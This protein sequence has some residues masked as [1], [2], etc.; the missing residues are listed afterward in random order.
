MIGAF[1]R[2]IRYPNLLMIIFIQYIVRY[3]LVKPV[4]AI[5]GIPLQMSELN[6]ALLVL[7]TVLIT[8]AGY[9]INDYFDLRI[10]RINKPDKIILGKKISRRK[11]IL[12]H[13][14]FSLFGI[15][16]GFYVAFSVGAIKLGFINAVITVLLWFYSAKYKQK[17][18]IG[19]V[20]VSILSAFVII[21]VWLFEF[22]ALIKSGTMFFTAS[23]SIFIYIMAYAAFAFLITLIREIIKDIEDIK[24]DSI[25]GCRTVPIVLGVQ[26]TKLFINILAGVCVVFL[27]YI[28]VDLYDLELFR[29]SLFLLIGLYLYLI[30]K[31][32]LAKEKDDFI[33]LS[34]FTKIIMIAGIL[35]MQIIYIN[36]Y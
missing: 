34:S 25:T 10:D 13:T 17:F 35:T 6:F 23:K 21:I 12:I 28:L 8:A 20:I 16:L 18:L 26:R 33:F 11:A 19:N 15:L 32:Q 29:Y 36:L 4:L 9:V 24:G 14:I 27:V 3:C 30:V 31:V 1:F 22:F 2:I 7:S 5:E